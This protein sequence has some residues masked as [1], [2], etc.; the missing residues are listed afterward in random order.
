LRV[1]V[2]GRSSRSQDELLHGKVAG[3][4]HSMVTISPKIEDERHVERHGDA[5]E[6]LEVDRGALGS[7][8]DLST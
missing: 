6:G 7:S 5:L 2:S 1:L 3:V 8:N 4:P